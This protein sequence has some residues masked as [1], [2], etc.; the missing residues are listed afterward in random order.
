LFF[1]AEPPVP[2]ATS[3]GEHV[4]FSPS[5]PDWWASNFLLELQRLTEEEWESSSSEVSEVMDTLGRR[6]EVTSVDGAQW[7][8]DAQRLGGS[9][10][11]IVQ[12]AEGREREVVAADVEHLYQ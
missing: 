11:L 9:G 2:H 3:I 8:G 10:S 6:V 4:S 7:Q 1:E 5:L 12:D